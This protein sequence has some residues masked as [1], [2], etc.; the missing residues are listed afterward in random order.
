MAKSQENKNLELCQQNAEEVTIL[1]K[2]N[3]NKVIER[4]GK[5]SDLEDR[6][7][8]LRN[9]ATAFEKTARTVERRTRWEK[10]RLYFIGGAIIAAVILILIIILVVQFG[11]G[12]GGDTAPAEDRATAGDQN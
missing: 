2:N 11:G 9:M 3:V 1:M 4:E 8:G 7:E 6:S 12:S 5:L 10:Y